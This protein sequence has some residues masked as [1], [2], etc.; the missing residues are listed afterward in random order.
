MGFVMRWNPTDSKFSDE[1][2][3]ALKKLNSDISLVLSY[4]LLLLKYINF[5]FFV[6]MMS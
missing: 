6:L 3:R 4:N 2:E 1:I 5:S